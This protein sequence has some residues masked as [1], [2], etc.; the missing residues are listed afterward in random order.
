MLDVV[1]I[2]ESMVLFTP[3]S[4]GM[5]RFSNQFTRKYGGAESNVAIGLSRLGHR[6][7]WVSK[8]GEDEFGKG[9]V[10][11]IKGEG[12]DVSNVTYSNDAPTGLY[13]KEFR[14]EGEINVFYYRKESAA[15]KMS[16]VDL[17]SSYIANA[18]Y[19]HITGITPALSESCYDMIFDVIKIAKENGVKVVFDPNL[20]RKLWGEE[21]A[22]ETLL[23]IAS[24]A[25]IVLPGIEEG[26]FMFGKKTP[27]ELG[28]SFIS[29]GAK[30]VVLKVG[31]EGAYYFTKDDEKRVTGFPVGR[32]IDPVGAGDGFAAGFLSGLLHNLTLEESVKR[33]NAVG[34]LVTMVSGDVEGLPEKY[35]IDRLLSMNNTDVD[36]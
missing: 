21:F 32:V 7:G 24:L 1:T 5:M 2:G 27:K 11:F 29:L 9:M 12:V 33:A 22:R 3:D 4:N 13:F 36:R 31:A 28:Q 26:Y 35:E 20:R 25:D 17:D 14:R 19:L 15:S 30:V 10:A 6:V 34:A 23:K 8:V 16:S 18:K